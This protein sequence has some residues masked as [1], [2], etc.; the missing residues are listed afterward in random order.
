MRLLSATHFSSLVAMGKG[1]LLMG[2]ILHV[3]IRLLAQRPVMEKVP[4]REISYRQLDSVI[5]LNRYTAVYFWPSWCASC[6]PKLQ[7]LT[8]MMR[9]HPSICFISVNDPGSKSWLPKDLVDHPNV[10]RGVF[11]IENHGRV[12]MISINDRDQLNYFHRYYT[13]TNDRINQVQNF[14]LF[15]ASGKL[16]LQTVK[17]D[18]R[19]DS[20]S[21]QLNMYD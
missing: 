9:S 5:H 4:V 14:Y 13:R 6:R 17:D 1:L 20:L 16:L 21:N 10:L 18:W 3:Q 15:D 2:T 19:A 11:R 8:E 7:Q 12:K